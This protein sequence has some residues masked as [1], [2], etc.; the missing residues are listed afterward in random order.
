MANITK[1][2]NES[3]KIW[4]DVGPAVSS[5]YFTVEKVEY[6]WQAIGKVEKAIDDSLSENYRSSRLAIDITFNI[7]REDET[8]TIDT[9]Y[10]FNI[11][12]PSTNKSYK[13]DGWAAYIDVVLGQ[14]QVKFVNW[15]NNRNRS[16]FTLRLLKKTVGITT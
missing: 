14:D 3:N 4:L 8:Y 9:D 6:T 5:Y 16:R 15:M 10:L 12:L 11:F 7:K 13:E 2:L 1:G